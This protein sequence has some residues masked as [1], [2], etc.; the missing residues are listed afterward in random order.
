MA[1]SNRVSQI[2]TGPFPCSEA[3]FQI[4]LPDIIHCLAKSMQ[5]VNRE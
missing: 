1:T 5:S 2:R 4:N 3:R